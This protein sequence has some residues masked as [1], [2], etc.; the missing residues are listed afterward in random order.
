MLFKNSIFQNFLF[1]RSAPYPFVTDQID[2]RFRLPKT[3]LER[4]TVL[5][6]GVGSGD[7]GL[8]R[9]LPYLPFFR[10]DM[11]DVY[12]PYLDNAA[13]K[14]YAA[15]ICHFIKADA[16]NF[17]TSPYDLVLMFDVLEHLEK[18]DSLFLLQKI[19]AKQIVFIPLEERYR[20]NCFG[21]KSQ[22]HLSF[23]TEDDFLKLGFKTERLFAFHRDCNNI[24]DALWAIKN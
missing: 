21:V 14:N 12:Q 19:K 22:D 2:L 7:S 3:G 10:L 6:I 20:E 24:F 16:R 9:Q 8:A 11:I 13:A 5:N 4:L 17:D 15:K 23:W 18:P 1:K